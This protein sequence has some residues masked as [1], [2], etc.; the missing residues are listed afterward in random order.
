M[1]ELLASPERCRRLGAEAR[2]R[3]LEMFDL[4]AHVDGLLGAYRNVLASPAS[5][6]DQPGLLRTS[7]GSY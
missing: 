6:L 5:G 4:S 3:A 7:P 1:T 2:T